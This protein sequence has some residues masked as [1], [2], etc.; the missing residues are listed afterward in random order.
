M[1]KVIPEPTDEQVDELY[2]QFYGE[3]RNLFNKYKGKYGYSENDTLVI[4]EAKAKSISPK[5]VLTNGFS[6]RSEV[7]KKSVS[8]GISQTNGTDN[9]LEN[10]TEC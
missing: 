3:I 1:E 8:N 9:S 10:K 6:S 4:K 5:Q 2:D 7:N